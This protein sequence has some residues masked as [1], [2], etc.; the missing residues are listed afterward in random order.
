M[1]DP[2]SAGT[3]P[4]SPPAGIETAKKEIKLISHS[5]LFY[6]WPVWVFGFFLAAWTLV[7]DD[8][9]VVA[10][11]NG[12]AQVDQKTKVQTNYKLD[13]EVKTAFEADKESVSTPDL[14]KEGAFT[15]G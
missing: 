6:W 5:T 9:L 1:P 8:R 3:A 11:A 14:A 2:T 7:E 10:P 12:K 15:I 4:A 13:Y